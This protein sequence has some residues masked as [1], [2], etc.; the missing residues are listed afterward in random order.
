M[1]KR[2]ITDVVETE[3]MTFCTWI[4]GSQRMSHIDFGDSQTLLLVTNPSYWMD[5]HDIYSAGIHVFQKDTVCF[6]N[7]ERSI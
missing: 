3:I 1:M 6:F 4:H 2:L 5:S 7:F